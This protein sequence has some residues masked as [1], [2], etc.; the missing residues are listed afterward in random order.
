MGSEMC[1]RDRDLSIDALRETKPSRVDVV[2][3]VLGDGN[4]NFFRELSK[5]GRVKIL[6]FGETS[7]E[8]GVK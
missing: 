3:K 1:I 6:D 2:N 4:L 8:V 7:V 5:K